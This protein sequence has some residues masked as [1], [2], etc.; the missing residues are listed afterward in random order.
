MS[1]F[2]RCVENSLKS[3]GMTRTDLA[4]KA[5][6]ALPNLSRLLNDER[7]TYADHA[8]AIIRALPDTHSRLDCLRCFLLDECP[9]EYREQL[10]VT[11][12]TGA[13]VAE[14]A[15]PY[16]DSLAEDLAKLDKLATNNRDLRNLIRN[17]ASL[18]D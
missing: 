12:T 18:L 2:T 15:A 1:R 3:R 10:S 9:D 17:L 11:F 6:M 7:P 5:G 16:R 14:D 13:Q 8:A 4:A